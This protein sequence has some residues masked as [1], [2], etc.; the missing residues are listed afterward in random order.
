MCP[1]GPGEGRRGGWLSCG[2]EAAG[3]E[4]DRAADA[5]GQPLT[6]SGARA[7]ERGSRV[8]AVPALD[9]AHCV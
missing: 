8:V 4:W 2:L 7:L 5:E 3:E 6:T 9:A 1:E